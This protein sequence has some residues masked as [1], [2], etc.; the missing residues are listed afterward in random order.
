MSAHRPI[1]RREFLRTS[2]AALA[3]GAVMG[4][5]AVARARPLPVRPG[6]QLYTLRLVL[7]NDFMGVFDRLAAI[8]YREVEFVGYHGR[9]PA[10]VRGALDAAGLASP[11][12]H[13]SIEDLEANTDAAIETAGVIGHRYLVIGSLPEDR[14]RTLDEYRRTADALNTLGERLRAAGLRLA[15][16]N[17][18][19]EFAEMGGTTGYDV[20]L[21]ETDRGNVAFQLDTYWITRAGRD[22]REY[23]QRNAGRFPLWHLKDTAGPPGHVMREVG[24]GVIEW[25][26]LF[27][28][29][30]RAGLEHAYVEH[31]EAGDPLRSVE[32]SWRFLSRM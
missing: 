27:A 22:P 10:A 7:P 11:S 12:A 23:I 14:R 24:S 1:H 30:G 19:V 9:T 4:P 2:A 26:S 21:R 6:V 18:D 17:H 5:M 16:H 15:F 28:L 32:T 8:G 25:D 29:A 31:D 3:A 13:F 20:L